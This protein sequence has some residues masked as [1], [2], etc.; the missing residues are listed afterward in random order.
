MYDGT[1]IESK[2]V[3]SIRTKTKYVNKPT[4]L[5]DYKEYWIKRLITGK[6]TH[7]WKHN[8]HGVK[9]PIFR[10]VKIEIVDSPKKYLQEGVLHTPKAI[11]LYGVVK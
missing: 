10:I 9:S 4:E 6:P 7:F 3:V 2:K 5:R 1:D 11:K 8:Q